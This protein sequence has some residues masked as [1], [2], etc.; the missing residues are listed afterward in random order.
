[1]FICGRLLIDFCAKSSGFLPVFKSGFRRFSVV[2][3]FGIP[4]FEC[5]NRRVFCCFFEL[6]FIVFVI[7]G[8]KIAHF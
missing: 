7:F 1:V 6:E 3:D 5:W 8:A 2:Y 4:G